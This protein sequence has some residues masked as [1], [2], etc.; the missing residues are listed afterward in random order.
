MLFNLLLVLS[1]VLGA[2]I[3][4]YFIDKITSV[5]EWIEDEDN[6][7]ENMNR[8]APAAGRKE[9]HAARRKVGKSVR[10]KHINLSFGVAEQPEGYPKCGPVCTGEL[11]SNHSLIRR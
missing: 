10:D 2:L 8:F 1:F 11:K 9:N 7:E 3:L 4:Y 5:V 6:P